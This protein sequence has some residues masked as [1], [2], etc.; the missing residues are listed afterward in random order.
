MTIAA[1]AVPRLWLDTLQRVAARGAHELR[2]VLN[3]AA[4]NLEV[5]R[6]RAG[7]PGADAAS[8]SHYAETAAQ[9]LERVMS[10]T[11]AFLNLARP[12]RE[13]A[14]V[15]AVIAQ[16]A[17]ILGPVAAADGGRLTLESGDEARTAAGGEAVRLVA[18]TVLLDALGRG[19]A[20]HCQ[21]AGDG[22]PVAELRTERGPVVLEGEVAVAAA[23][24]GIR[25][26]PTADGI[27]LR[28]PAP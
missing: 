9:E 8:I 1:D 13:P 12:P 26:T 17:S 20:V 22:E 24:A 7:R 6:S 5:V 10:M 25:A 2:N 4:V 28:F 18:A 15:G 23:D 14:D 27:T 16:L 11:E 19:G 3:G 21:V